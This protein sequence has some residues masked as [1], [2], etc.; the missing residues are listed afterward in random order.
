MDDILLSPL[1]NVVVEY[2]QPSCYENSINGIYF[3]G[4]KTWG[5]DIC[6]L[7]LPHEEDNMIN[8]LAKKTK[9][10]V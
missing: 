9:V 5:H 2:L 8:H 1:E 10:L 4:F 6:V 3:D 7:N